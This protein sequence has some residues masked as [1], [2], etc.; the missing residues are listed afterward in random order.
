MIQ[1][2]KTVEYGDR[3]EKSGIIK[4]EV[5]PI[6]ATPEGTTFLVIDWDVT[7]PNQ[8]PIH[9]KEV[10]W[11]K[12]EIDTMDAYLESNYD[13]S[14]LTKTEKEWQKMQLALLIDTQ[15]NL[16]AS[17]KTIYRLTPDDW[18]LC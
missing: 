8:D 1:T 3:S 18:E 16:F 10:L 14:Q 9:S 6:L 17:G 4:V 5:R 2:T 7:K 11:T 12:L 13:F 15:S